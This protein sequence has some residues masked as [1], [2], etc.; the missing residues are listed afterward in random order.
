MLADELRLDEDSCVRE[1]ASRDL[2]EYG[3]ALAAL[4]EPTL[5]RAVWHRGLRYPDHAANWPW[6]E[7]IARKLA[8]VDDE[9]D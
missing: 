4:D 7:R 5:A 1:G 6:K 2:L 3:S 8:V 9:E